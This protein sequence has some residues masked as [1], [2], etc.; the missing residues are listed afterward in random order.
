MSGDLIRRTSGGAVKRADPALRRAVRRL[1]REDPEAHRHL[2]WIPPLEWLGEQPF[3]IF[4]HH[5]QLKGVLACPPDQSGMCWLRLFAAAGG[6]GR[7]EVWSLLWS[8][9]LQDLKD[10][11][12]VDA[13]HALVVESGLESL[14]RSTGFEQI[15]EVVVLDWEV[16]P[17]RVPPGIPEIDL[18]LLTLKDLDQVHQLDSRSFA[19]I[20]RN[21]R[22]QIR[23]AF[24][25]AAFVVGAFQEGRLVGFQISTAGALAGHLARLAV[26]PEARGR[27]IGKA[28]VADALDRFQR[29]GMVRVSVNTQRDNPASLEIYRQFGFVLQEGSFPVYAY[30]VRDEPR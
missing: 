22:R 15:A 23:R 8:A 10:R 18:R 24:Q 13:V 30:P 28:L 1:M 4:E 14:L 6:V 12:G 5:W 21:T 9:A 27:G 19:P 25:E 26:D 7:R 29:Q 20:W 3:L 11:G 17:G 16:G 2:G